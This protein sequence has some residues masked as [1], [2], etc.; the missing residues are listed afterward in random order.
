M[1]LIIYFYFLKSKKGITRLQEQELGSLT[2][3]RTTVLQ[4]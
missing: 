3:A 1:G 4:V 2:K